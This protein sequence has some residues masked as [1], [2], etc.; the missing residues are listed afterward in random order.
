MT[1]K[2]DRYPVVLL[3]TA[4]AAT[5]M[6][7]AA[8]LPEDASI[9]IHAQLTEDEFENLTRDDSTGKPAHMKNCVA[10]QVTGPDGWNITYNVDEV[11]AAEHSRETWQERA[12]NA[13]RVQA[14]LPE[15]TGSDLVKVARTREECSLRTLS[16]LVNMGEWS[17]IETDVV[18]DG[19]IL[20]ALD[21][22]GVTLDDLQKEEHS[23]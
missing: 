12:I 17:V 18:G 9:V 14:G 4:P 10:I 20:S 1:E 13:L 8:G 5:A 21:S 2:Q 11:M 22:A 7:Q 19:E 16:A 3:A 23:G 15:L 6:R